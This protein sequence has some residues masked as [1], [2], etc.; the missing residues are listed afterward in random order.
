MTVWILFMAAIALLLA[1][2]L[3]VLNR[4]AHVL[5]LKE[6]TIWTTFWVVLGLGFSIGV[7]FIYQH[8]WVANPNALTPWDAALKYVTGYLVEL[9]LSM[10]NIFV[11]A[12]IFSSFAVPQKYQHRVL[13]WGILGA[14]LFRISAIYLGVALLKKFYW[15]TYFFGAFLAFTA[16]RLLRSHSNPDF[17]TKDSLIFKWASKM[18]PFTHTITSQKF[19]VREKGILKATPLFVSLIIIEFTDILFAL[20][21]IPAVLAI[22]S[23]PFL[24]FSSNIL[25]V[26]GLRSLYFFLSHMISRFKYLRYS[27][28]AILFFV[29]VK[30]ILT[31]YITIPEWLSLGIIVFSLGIGVLFSLGQTKSEES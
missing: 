17:H 18:I 13:F 28:A 12:I 6:T 7:Y 8:S 20:D 4:K 19:F 15:I 27:L 25:A 22:T 2:D 31:H 1:F 21:S 3:G 11:I 26:M 30:L 9:S 5:S 14:I 10:D 23:D 24:V 29:G 16:V